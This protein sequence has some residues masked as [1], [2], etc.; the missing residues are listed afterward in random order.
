MANNSYLRLYLAYENSYS[1]YSSVMVSVINNSGFDSECKIALCTGSGPIEQKYNL[2]QHFGEERLKGV[3]TDNVN[4]YV[5]ARDR[6]INYYLGYDVNFATEEE[7]ERIEQTDEF[8]EMPVYPYYGSVK[9]IDNYIV[10]R[11]SE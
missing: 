4:M 2:T 9:K 10:V 6:F 8:K 11:L 7:L 1:Y 5:M 3:F